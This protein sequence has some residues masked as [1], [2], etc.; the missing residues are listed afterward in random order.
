MVIAALRGKVHAGPAASVFGNG[1]PSLLPVLLDARG[2]QAG[3]AM[4]VDGI[5]PG[6]EFLDGERVAAAG[7]FQREQAAAH[8]GHDLGFATDDP[9]LC[10]RC[11]QVRDGQRTAVRADDIF[12]P[13]PKGLR[14][15]NTHALD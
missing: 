2:A 15:V 6:E 8:R 7:F 13:W 10:A 14:H 9:T 12:R 1:L 11:G 4:L 5:L 3:E